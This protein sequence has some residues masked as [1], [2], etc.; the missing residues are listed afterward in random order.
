MSECLRLLSG[1]LW[2]KAEIRQNLSEFERQGRF[3]RSTVGC[4]MSWVLLPSN[5]KQKDARWRSVIALIVPDFPIIPEMVQ[6]FNQ[7]LRR[8]PDVGKLDLLLESS[9]GDEDSAVEIARLCFNYTI[10]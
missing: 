7:V 4:A 8:M 5:T 2:R 6:A 3:S 10:G 1:P 9:G